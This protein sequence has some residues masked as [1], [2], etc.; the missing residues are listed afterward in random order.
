MLRV[1]P[2]MTTT[3]LFLQSISG[4]AQILADLL[5]MLPSEYRGIFRTRP[6]RENLTV[7]MSIALMADPKLL[8]L[9]EP[10]IGLSPNLVQSILQTVRKLADENGL[11]AVIVEQNVKVALDVADYVLALR[12][13]RVIFEGP[14]SEVSV[15]KLWDL[16]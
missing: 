5:H 4:N 10:S 15:D 8:L 9:D 13:G 6:V 11:A 2:V 7:A 16:F 1:P 3:I 14:A 12:G